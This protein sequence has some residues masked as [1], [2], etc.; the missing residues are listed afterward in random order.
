MG[1][2]EEDYVKRSDRPSK[3]S[4]RTNC[5][6]SALWLRRLS[7]SLGVAA[8]PIAF[9]SLSLV[10]TYFVSVTVLLFPPN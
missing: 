9:L 10:C 3:L 7:P 2:N 6:Q 4:E 5:N 8:I 1:V